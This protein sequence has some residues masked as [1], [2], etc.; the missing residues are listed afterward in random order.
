M[1]VLGGRRR[2]AEGAPWWKRHGL[3][4]VLMLVLVAQT[5]VFIP[6]A[7]RSWSSDQRAHDEPVAWWPDFATYATSEWFVSV[8]AD[9]Y[10]AVLLVLATKWFYESGSSESDDLPEEGG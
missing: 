10:G 4:L 1:S 6:L 9:T 8:L 5:A 7:W 2:W 3:S